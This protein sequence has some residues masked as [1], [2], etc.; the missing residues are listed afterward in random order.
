MDSV[1]YIIQRVDRKEITEAAAAKSIRPLINETS[2]DANISSLQE[3]IFRNMNI[4]GSLLI[5][6]IDI[7]IL[8]DNSILAEAIRSGRNIIAKKLF[9]K[10]YM[11]SESEYASKNVKW[12]YRRKQLYP[13]ANR[14]LAKN[15]DRQAGENH[16]TT[17]YLIMGHGREEKTSYIVPKGCM[18]VVDVHSGELNYGVKF[19]RFFDNTIDKE[20]FLNPIDNYAELTQKI[21]NKKSLAIYREGDE[22]P[23]FTYHLIS[24]WDMGD[25]DR[26]VIVPNTYKLL[27]SGIAQY[28]FSDT[29]ERGRIRQISYDAGPSLLIE[30]FD[31]SILPTMKELSDEVTGHLTSV[32]QIIDAEIPLL[33]I[34]Q[35]E[36]FKRVKEK[37]L[38]AGV[39]Y[40]LICRATS[41]DILEIPEGNLTERIKSSHRMSRINRSN[42]KPNAPPHNTFGRLNL[43]TNAP[44]NASFSRKNV[45][46]PNS[47]KNVEKIYQDRI[48]NYVKKT[49]IVRKLLAKSFP[50]ITL[51]LDNI[52]ETLGRVMIKRNM[53]L[54]M[55]QPLS[56]ED[57]TKRGDAHTLVINL[58]GLGG[59]L[60][61][62][63]ILAEMKETIRGLPTISRPV[64]TATGRDTQLLPPEISQ[65]IGEAEI[66]RK[67]FT[68]NLNLTAKNRSDRIRLLISKIKPRENFLLMQRERLEIMKDQI[69]GAKDL[70]TRSHTP[71]L[72]E[73]YEG[74]LKKAEIGKARAENYIRDFNTEEF[75]KER[76][77]LQAYGKEPTASHD[78][79][80]PMN[81]TALNELIQ[82][83]QQ[84]IESLDEQLKTT[85][86][87]ERIRTI[88]SIM[89][90]DR[91]K[92]IKQLQRLNS[93]GLTWKRRG[94][95]WYGE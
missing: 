80:F 2:D 43:F 11:P 4:I 70:L 45:N 6:K 77:E 29:A 41:P 73:E 10:G 3:A 16:P 22:Y 51:N 7:T 35:S 37:K 62:K 38:E 27:D 82:G 18:L 55:P 53:L 36:L 19:T 54:E 44:P 66:Q 30:K 49:K 81:I 67:R 88:Q 78:M 1:Y 57:A 15:T 64:A 50:D 33:Y 72:Q 13:Q 47:S 74:L 21:S 31:L 90:D 79:V 40:N 32:K 63:N 39:F 92:A 93:R 95:K 76:R 68:R 9:E 91:D 48:H 89:A 59:G 8:Q 85:N 84:N 65:Q 25:P 12:L 87:P 26:T 61:P 5:D 28:P 20:K 71:A 69:H 94:K 75:R 83:M 58:V 86:D 24:Y 46:N 23:D 52:R 14:I 60:K 56:K 42:L 34:K 17:A